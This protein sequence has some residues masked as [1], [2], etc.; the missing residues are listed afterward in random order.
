MVYLARDMEVA[1]R[2]DPRGEVEADEEEG[3]YAG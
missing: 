2:R 1:G 3:E